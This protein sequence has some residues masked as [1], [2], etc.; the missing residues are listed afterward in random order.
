[1]GM[2]RGDEIAKAKASVCHGTSAHTS[3]A[4]ANLT[5]ISARAFLVDAHQANRLMVQLCTTQTPMLH[6][7]FSVLSGIVCLLVHQGHLTRQPGREEEA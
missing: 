7:W 2:E 6:Q 5:L 3:G 1:M 4:R